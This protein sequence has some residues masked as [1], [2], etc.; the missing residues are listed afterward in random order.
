VV[1]GLFRDLDHMMCDCSSDMF[2]MTN[3]DGFDVYSSS[4]SS[5]GVKS[6]T[7]LHFSF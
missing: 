3:E 7:H 4:K 6:K 1:S 5:Q 2:D